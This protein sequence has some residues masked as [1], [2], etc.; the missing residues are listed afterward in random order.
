MTPADL[1]W[2]GNPGPICI[3]CEDGFHED[4]LCHIAV[5][6]KIVKCDC[7]CHRVRGMGRI[8][9]ETA[10]QERN[11]EYREWDAEREVEHIARF[12]RG[13]FPA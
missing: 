5:N 8:M 10:E 11:R 4:P 6:D 3:A 13:E 9:N 1:I 2:E 12:Y 7:E